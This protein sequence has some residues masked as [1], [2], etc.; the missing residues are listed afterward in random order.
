MQEKTLAILGHRGIPANYGGFETLAEQISPILAN[1]GFKVINYCRSYLK[2]GEQKFY[3][4]SKLIYLPCFKYKSLETLSHTFL[5]T[6][7]L[8]FH[9]T[10]YALVLNVGNAF[11]ALLLKLR[12]IK[13]VLNVDGFEWKRKKWGLLARGFFRASSYLAPFSS[14]ALITDSWAVKNFYQTKHG[15]DI[16]MIPY[17]ATTQKPP[18]DPDVLNDYGLKPKGYFLYLAR[19]EEENNPLFV[20]ELYEKLNINLPLVMIGDVT[21]A[22]HYTENVKAT[23]N[24]KIKF[25]GAVY[26]QRAKVLM[27]NALA[28]IRASEVGGLSPALIEMMGL[29]VCVIANETSA[30]HQAMGNDGLFYNFKD[31]SLLKIINLI[32]ERPQLAIEMGQQLKNRA[33]KE[34]NWPAIGRAYSN[35]I[36]FL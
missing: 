27:A 11:F 36:K 3:Q 18:I 1:Q 21:Y 7:H 9:P 28:Y 25:L 30:N 13:V 17:G 15:K 23:E 2:Q 35:L 34:F 6:W 5:A 26:G 20:R 14:N 10:N 32:A 8:Y 33:H 19:F 24:S 4:G 16:I 31:D 22:S 29:G 12:G